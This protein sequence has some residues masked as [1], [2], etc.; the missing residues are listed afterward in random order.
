MVW[1][2]ENAENPVTPTQNSPQPPTA[3][4]RPRPSLKERFQT[5][6]TEYGFVGLAVHYAIFFLS[7]GV[8]ALLLHQGVQVFAALSRFGFEVESPTSTAGILGVSYLASQAIKIP[9]IAATFALTPPVARLVRRL[10]RK[11]PD[12]G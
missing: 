5:L 7:V 10:R 11:G 6:L 1:T 2:M 3:E 12:A 9:R 4:A 8:F